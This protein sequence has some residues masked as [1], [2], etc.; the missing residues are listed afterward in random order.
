MKPLVSDGLWARLEPL[1]PRPK[2][3]RF[4][5]PGRKPLDR[6]KILTGILFVL[7]TGI[8]WDDLP[9][10]M[11]C[12]CGKTCRKYL[13]RW[14]RQGLWKRLQLVLLAELD[15]AHLIDWGRAAVDSASCRAPCGGRATGPNPTDRRKLGTKHH[16]IVAGDGVP[17][18]VITTKANRADCTQLIP[19]LNTLPEIPRKRGRKHRYPKRMYGDRGYDD[20]KL[21]WACVERGIVPYLPHRRTKHGSGLGVVRWV[22]ERTLS[23]LHQF[24][25][26]GYRRD[27]SLTLHRAFVLLAL[28]VIYMR[29]LL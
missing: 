28:C 3:R 29:F 14:Y 2:T 11:G 7:K 15:D 16:I 9:A 24:R 5:H 10:E 6:R 4:R 20:R 27:R 19:L 1:L 13:R 8:A 17:L 22:V 18:A 26:V 12:G 21:R 23:W 25:R